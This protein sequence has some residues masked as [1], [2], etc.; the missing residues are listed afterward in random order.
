MVA[1]ASG[2]GWR[3]PDRRRTLVRVAIVSAVLGAAGLVL[4]LGVPER[5]S[6]DQLR[7][8]RILLIGFVHAHPWESVL[9]Y[10]V[11]YTLVVSL[12]VPGALVMTLTGGF[13]FGGVEGAAAAV[14]GV[15]LGCIVMFLVA[16][17]ALGG[18]L[19][20]WLSARSATLRRLE[21][22]MRHHPFTTILALRLIPAA[23]ICL[24]NLAAGFVRAPVAP[25][26]AATIL[27]VIPSTVLYTYVGAGLGRMF[28]TVG[29]ADLMG[30]IRNHLALPA[31]GLAMLAVLPLG[32]RWWSGRRVAQSRRVK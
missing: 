26:A 15:S 24:V 14:S 12:S 21:A 17:T 5:L 31:L 9:L 18:G 11:A 22:E 19:S 6:L 13:L 28:Q 8:Q 29:T 27:G 10:V 7:G 2:G 30:V 20:A 1:I 3:S 32:L 23:P 16:R 4:W 25:F